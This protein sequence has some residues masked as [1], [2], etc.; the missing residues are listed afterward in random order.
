MGEPVRKKREMVAVGDTDNVVFL[1]GT[2]RDFDRIMRMR[3]DQSAPRLAYVDG[4][5]EIMSPSRT[6]EHAK[7]A[8]GCL[9]EAYCFHRGIR[10]TPV[11]SWTLE[12]AK[13]APG[14]P[15]N[16]VEPDECYIFG[17]LD[18]EATVPHM[19]IEIIWTSA[20]LD[21]SR[22]YRDLGVRELWTWRRGELTM[23]VLEQRTWV[24]VDESRELPGLR[25]DMLR[26][27]LTGKTVF[28]AVNEFRAALA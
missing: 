6:H 4:W 18:E 26:P 19:V 2:R 24:E 1:R 14:K 8:L 21:K 5:I 9:V 22:L 7:S 3:G 13:A 12:L 15:K 27:H 25:V 28:D 11:G 16:A 20:R 23:A 17:E 10:F